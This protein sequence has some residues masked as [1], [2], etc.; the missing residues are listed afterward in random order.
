M[1]DAVGVSGGTGSHVAVGLGQAAGLSEGLRK[2]SF[3][4]S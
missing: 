2:S 1:N 3:L 4:G